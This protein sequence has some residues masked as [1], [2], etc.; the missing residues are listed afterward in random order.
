MRMGPGG[1]G[2]STKR[3]SWMAS[4]EKMKNTKEV[5]TSTAFLL[6]IARL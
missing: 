6:A 5:I 4:E 1:K 3:L 2:G